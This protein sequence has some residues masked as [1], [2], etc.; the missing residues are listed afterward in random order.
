MDIIINMLA[1]WGYSFMVYHLCPINDVS[2]VDS[3]LNYYSF[4]NIEIR[5]EVKQI[6]EA[7]GGCRK[8]V[9]I[10]WPV[11]RGYIYSSFFALL[12][13]ITALAVG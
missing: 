4:E 10:E 7:E 12:Y 5:N 2:R 3:P 8:D 9:V 13:L 11:V 1:I 6:L